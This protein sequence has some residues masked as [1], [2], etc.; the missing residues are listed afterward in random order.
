ME[1]VY[2]LLLADRDV[3]DLIDELL[4]GDVDALIRVL[5]RA[6]LH[7]LE[8]VLLRELLR[9]QP[10]DLPL[11]LEV[12]LVADQD[13]LDFRLARELQ[14]VDPLARVVEGVQARDVVDD[15]RADRL[16][17][18]AHRDRL[19]LL[20]SGSVPELELGG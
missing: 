19:V 20:L 15:E 13:Y 1:I 14:V 3:P 9:D 4:E 6:R 18:V 5:D 17:E 2:G 10:V 12:H 8:A 7:E 11:V 16:P